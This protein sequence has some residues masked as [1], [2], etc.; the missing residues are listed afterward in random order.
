MEFF[1]L[2]N[3]ANTLTQVIRGEFSLSGLWVSF[4]IGLGL[5]LIVLVFGGLGLYTMASRV[6][7]K[8][9]WLGFIPFVNTFYAGK[10]AGEAHFFGQKMK[11]H[12][13]YAMLAEIVYAGI[14]IAGLLTSIFLSNPNYWTTD[15]EG[16]MTFVPELVPAQYQWVVTA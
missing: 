9:P 10:V 1:D 5:Y 8:H 6:G 4:G 14:S 7:L 12:G 13:L 16:I 2:F 11:R 15:A 3:F